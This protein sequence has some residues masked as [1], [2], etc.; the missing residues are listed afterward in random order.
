MKKQIILLSILAALLSSCGVTAVIDTTYEKE[1]ELYNN[2][3]FVVI[4][5]IQKR[6]VYCHAKDNYMIPIYNLKKQ[7]SIGDTMHLNNTMRPSE[8]YIMYDWQ[9][10]K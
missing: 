1:Q 2:T 8:I 9:S 10:K 7:V 6:K 3:V 4:D 5:S